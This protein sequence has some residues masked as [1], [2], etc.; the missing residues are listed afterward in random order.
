MTCTMKILTS[1]F[2]FSLMF[3]STFA[4]NPALLPPNVGSKAASALELVSS[5][6]SFLLHNE[7]TDQKGW[8]A[9]ARWMEFERERLN[10][11][12]VMANPEIFLN[13]ASQIAQEKEAQ[14]R[15]K[16][17]QGWSP[18][19]PFEKPGTYSSSPSYGMGRIN[20][21]TF[22]PT[23]PNI[24]WIGVAQGGVWKTINGG[25]SYIPLTDNLPIL[26]IS[27]IAVDPKNPDILYVSA[28]DYAYIGV[29]LNTDGRKR[30]SHYGLGVYKTTDGGLNWTPTG[31]SFEQSQLDVTLIRRVL[32][33]PDDSN[34]LLAAGVSGIFKSRDA[35]ASWSQ[36]RDD[37]IWDFEQ[38]PT[39][40]NVIYASPGYVQT[41]GK[42]QAGL[43]KSTDFG[44]N[45]TTLSPG[46]PGNRSIARVEIG[47]TPQTSDYVY[48]IASD[49]SGGFYG[50]YRSTD[51]GATWQKRLDYTSGINILA[52]STNG[53]GSGG[54]GWYDLAI[55]VDPKNKERVYIGGINMWGTENGGSTWEACSYWV[56]SNGFT[57]HADHHQYKYN[58]A[59]DKYYACQDGGVARTD[60][61]IL[62]ADN[63][64]KWNTKWEERS[65]GMAIT[66]FYRLGLSEMFPGY[67]IAGAQDNSTFFNQNGTWVNIM[68]GDGMEAMIHPDNPQIIYGSSQYGSWSRSDDGGR[69][70]RGIRADGYSEQG[71]WTTPMIMNP[72][73]PNEIYAGYGNVWKS[74]NQGNGW[75]KISNF[76]LISGYGY[77]AV[78]SALAICPTDPKHIYIGKRPALGYNEV[79]SFWCTH[80]GEHWEDVT[81]GLPDSLYFSYIAVDDSDPLSV[82]V[83]C[84]GFVA[85]NK[86]FHSSDGGI[87]WENVSYN[88]PNIPA[89]T[90]VHQ[91]GSEANIVYLGTD[92]GVYYTSDGA[93]RWELY[94]TDLPNVIIS[95]LEIHYPSK[96]LYAATF[97]RGIWMADLASALSSSQSPEIAQ[98][99][100]EVYPNPSNGECSINFEGLPEGEIH[101]EVI[102]VQGKPVFVKEAGY[103]PGSG[104]FRIETELQAGVY[105]LRLWSGKTVRSSRILIR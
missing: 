22:H 75:Q 40:G 16:T 88:L 49:N 73:N 4:Q 53:S 17:G 8:K 66:S 58:P 70:F 24:Y 86:V 89:N 67:V 42:G 23:N 54:Q 96:K 79:T 102:D 21:I 95:E 94:S 45:W 47:L 9:Y 6:D 12:A 52:W 13:A 25:E 98:T 43:I 37:L 105:F 59:D 56:M 39:N 83:T 2:A 44:E 61:I 32:I 76:P 69:S 41:L 1:L 100:L 35:G 15:L 3:F 20:C 55:L 78:I 97:G 68:G 18:V 57:L 46:F 71:G 84:S 92:A 85:G 11:G 26:R 104:S 93:D 99:L 103:F 87:S 33:S 101:L 48:L 82:W 64:G 80:D 90:I 14:A 19:G 38:D 74:T 77:P 72:N 28:C 34:V 63:S 10:P 51:A 7:P 5:Y 30:H 60:T 29:A 31:L 27:D 81:A 36:L 65:N 50:F 62:G 91:N